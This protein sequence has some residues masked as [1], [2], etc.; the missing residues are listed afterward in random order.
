MPP[1]GR[2]FA[3][4][5]VVVLVVALLVVALLV[6]VVLLAAAAAGWFGGQ[7]RTITGEPAPGSDEPPA[8]AD[9][10]GDARLRHLRP[11]GEWAP[12]PDPR[13]DVLDTAI[14]QAR[15]LVVEV[16]NAD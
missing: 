10:L 13:R 6:V 11:V 7:H 9:V 3:R 2:R 4:S 5:P 15:H 12:V 1:V 14:A 16:E 8:V